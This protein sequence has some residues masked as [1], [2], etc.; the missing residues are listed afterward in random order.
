MG[1]QTAMNFIY[2]S[3]PTIP[4]GDD[5]RIVHDEAGRTWSVH[6]LSDRIDPTRTRWSLIF[7]G[8][9]SIR[10]VREYPADW[11][12]LSDIALMELSLRR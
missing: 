1:Q 9:E 12:E 2:K 8:A 3:G 6:E 10:R 4:A 5:D 11:R 7:S